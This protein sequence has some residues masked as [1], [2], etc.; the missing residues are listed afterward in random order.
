MR[1]G[2]MMAQKE[3]G[4]GGG[5]LAAAAERQAGGAPAGAPPPGSTGMDLALYYAMKDSESAGEEEGLR[6][7]MPQF[8]DDD[9]TAGKMRLLKLNPSVVYSLLIRKRYPG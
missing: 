9:G 2:H 1:A 6:I 5:S 3:G 4:Q 7:E 8:G